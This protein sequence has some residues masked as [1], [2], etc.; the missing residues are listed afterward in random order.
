MVTS[1]D[2]QMAEQIANCLA[3]KAVEY[4]PEVM[5]TSAPNIAESAIVPMV[6][7]SPNNIRNALMGGVLCANLCMG[8]L[9]VIP[10]WHVGR[11]ERRK[12]KE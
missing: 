7:S 2:P 4:L 10:E 1:D 6:K 11:R 5:E 12:K 8:I 3:E 9:A